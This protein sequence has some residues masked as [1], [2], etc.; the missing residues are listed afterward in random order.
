[1]KSIAPIILS[2][3]ERIPVADLSVASDS[4]WRDVSEQIVKDL[5]RDFLQDGLYRVHILAKPQVWRTPDGAKK[6]ASDGKEKLFNGKNFIT[7]MERLLKIFGDPEKQAA[8]TW[9]ENLVHDL[10]NGVY[11]QVVATHDDDETLMIAH[12]VL[13][14]DEDANRFKRTDVKD[15]CDLVNRVRQT[16]AGGS[17]TETGKILEGKLG[18]H[19]RVFVWRIVKTASALS[20]GTVQ[21]I[22][23]AG[24]PASWIHDNDFFVGTGASAKKWMTKV[25]LSLSTGRRMR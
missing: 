8:E 20:P 14:H 1:M 18:L 6:Y 7:C 19:R 15:Q 22:R 25:A 24:V 17:W 23:D 10:E 5:M 12:N 2:E 16:V 9:T 11:C 21:K 13:A 4:S 3:D